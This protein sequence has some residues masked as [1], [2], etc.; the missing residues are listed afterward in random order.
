[1]SNRL[2]V[3]CCPYVP[4]RKRARGARSSFCN[5][6]PAVTLH[7]RL[8]KLGAFVC[9]YQAEAVRREYELFP[10]L[11]RDRRGLDDEVAVDSSMATTVGA[12]LDSPGDPEVRG[13]PSGTSIIRQ[14][15]AVDETE[16]QEAADAETW[17]D[18]A[19]DTEYLVE[20]LDHLELCP[21][22]CLGL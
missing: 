19:G 4:C 16:E 17:Y 9:T 20:L 10:N 18:W 3:A 5:E 7:V 6:A 22:L 11:A 2:P 15:E 1:M 12:P 21:Q 8:T 13:G 14:A